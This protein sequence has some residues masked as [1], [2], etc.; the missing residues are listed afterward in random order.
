VTYAAGSSATV[1]WNVAGTDRAPIGTAKVD[2]LLSRDG[3][4][5]FTV[6]AA[7]V[8]NDGDAT[9]TLPDA[10]TTHARIEVRAV[11]NVFF[12]VNASEFT[13]ADASAHAGAR[14]AF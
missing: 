9:V 8:A 12:A 11:G 13:I 5:H 1:H 14:R 3:G 7:N 6:L 2:V 4:A 10:T